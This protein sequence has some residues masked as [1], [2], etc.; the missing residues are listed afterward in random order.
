MPSFLPKISSKFRTALRC[1]KAAP[2]FPRRFKEQNERIF[3]LEE[4][5]RESQANIEAMKVHLPAVLNYITSFADTSRKLTRK[6]N[7]IEGTLENHSIILVNHKTSIEELWA[8][9]EL[10]RRE[11]LYE[12]MYGSNQH[13]EASD[14]HVSE[15]KIINEKKMKDMED[16]IRI[17]IGCGNIPVEGY[18]NLDRREL[19]GVDIVADA[20]NLP[21][22]TG[23]VGE[24]FSAHLIEHFPQ[25]EFVRVVLPHW[26][27]LLKPGGRLHATLPDW[28]AMINEFSKG[29]YPFE[30][31][32][33][34]TFGA[35]DYNGDFHYNM[36]S[37]ESLKKI[38]QDAG[39]ANITF[40]VT[41]RLND[42][43]YEMEVSAEKK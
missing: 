5:Q 40:P 24:I 1:A 32:R 19:P 8:R 22:E 42:I 25:Q 20:T 27:S 6:N 21:F 26:V 17:N 30:H 13:L 38:M 43:C 14:G 31:L 9:I 12:F 35:Q 41:G 28:E 36:F 7:E 11:L 18:L 23:S 29:E 2:R 34:V 10:V 39:L 3:R 4:A 16:D 33:L 15:I 37:R